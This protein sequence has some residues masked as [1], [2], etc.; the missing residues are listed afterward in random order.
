MHESGKVDL[1]SVR[2]TFELESNLVKP[3]NSVRPIHVTTQ[4]K[5]L[6]SNG[7]IYSAVGDRYIREALQSVESLKKVSP[8][9]HTTIFT[10]ERVNSKYFDNEIA[11]DSESLHPKLQKIAA[12][13]ESPYDKTVFLDTDTYIC[14]ELSEV[15][16]L[17]DR[18]DVAL[19]HAP[20]RNADKKDAC[21]EYG[22]HI[23]GCFPEMNTGVIAFRT[24]TATKR[25]FKNWFELANKQILNQ[26]K[27]LKDQFP[28][29]EA[30][31]L[32]DVRVATLTPEY[33]FRTFLCGFAQG[34]IKILHG[35]E[36]DMS[37]LETDVNSSLAPRVIFKRKSKKIKLEVTGKV[38]FNRFRGFIK[39]L[40]RLFV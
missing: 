13:M 19:A 5:T 15:F 11:I 8:E 1:Y 9:L 31:Y 25:L 24:N 14:D 23:P 10:S 6:M 17:L 22:V 3:I 38:F 12:L 30:L 33:N 34:K 2:N 32:S 27:Y 36:T 20:I 37:K 21:Y 35:R 40:P 39:R 26:G 29:R 18:F 7:V 28:F 4:L 16:V